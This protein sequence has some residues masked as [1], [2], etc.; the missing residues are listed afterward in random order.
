MLSPEMPTGIEPTELRFDEERSWKSKS[1]KR[2]GCFGLRLGALPQ[3]QPAVVY[4]IL[5][6]TLNSTAALRDSQQ[7]KLTGATRAQASERHRLHYTNHINT[8]GLQ[9]D[10][11]PRV[12][13]L[14]P[15]PSDST[16]V[17]SPRALNRPAP[18]SASSHTFG[19]MAEQWDV[20]IFSQHSKLSGPCLIHIINALFPFT[21]PVENCVR[22]V[23]KN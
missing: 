9:N 8:K 1:R 15:D 2:C 3:E 17:L 12:P 11:C 6:T 19:V 22:M 5:R 7:L 18:W 13:C 23:K 21:L 20:A 4:F 10:E 16:N 14:P